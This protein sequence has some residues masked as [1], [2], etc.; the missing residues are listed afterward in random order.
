MLVLKR[1]INDSVVLKTPDG[2]ELGRVVML[3]TNGPGIATIGF[4]FPS[5]IRIERVDY[6]APA[7][8]SVQAIDT[9]GGSP[10][11]RADEPRAD[12]LT[13]AIP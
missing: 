13:N 7:P 5:Y 2:V 11:M 9:G 8:E 3:K 1:W 12:R 10:I 6:V 4:D